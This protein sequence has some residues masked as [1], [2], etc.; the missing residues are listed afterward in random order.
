MPRCTIH[1][2]STL[3]SCANSDCSPE[4]SSP[5]LFG[6]I[7]PWLIG[8]ACSLWPWIVGT[9]TILTQGAVYHPWISEIE[10]LR[11]PLLDNVTRSHP[12][13]TLRKFIREIARFLDIVQPFPRNYPTLATMSHNQDEPLRFRQ[14]T[15]PDYLRSYRAI[16]HST[17][18]FSRRTIEQSKWLT[19]FTKCYLR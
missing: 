13:R 11:T 18:M 17:E 8:L 19:N 9:T 15:L 7:L 4:G 2:S 10:R 5:G 16:E 12:C 14:A 1:R 3:N 6:L